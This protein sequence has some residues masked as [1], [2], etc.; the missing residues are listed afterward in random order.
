MFKAKKKERS[1]K[2]HCS[3]LFHEQSFLFKI[4]CNNSAGSV[5]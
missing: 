1:A 2:Y 3:C 4:P 5:A